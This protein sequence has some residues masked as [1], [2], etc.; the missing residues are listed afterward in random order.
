MEAPSAL[1]PGPGRWSWR[2]SY[3]TSFLALVIRQKAKA[4]PEEDSEERPSLPTILL[5]R[6]SLNRGSLDRLPRGPPVVV[7]RGHGHLQRPDVD[8]VGVVVHGRE[9]EHAVVR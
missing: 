6:G 5:W 8:G 9:P 1:L 7:G 2:S 3:G 4:K